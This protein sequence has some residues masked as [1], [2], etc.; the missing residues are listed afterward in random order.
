MA[1]ILLFLLIITY[2]PTA[3]QEVEPCL[4]KIKYRKTPITVD[5]NALFSPI[6]PDER[7]HILASWENFDATSSAITIIKTYNIRPN[8]KAHIISHTAEGKVHY[9]AIIEP[10]Q[11]DDTRQYPLLSFPFGLNQST[12]YVGLDERWLLDELISPLSD[13]WI[14]IPSFRG[15]ALVAG[16]HFYCSDGFFGDAYDGATDDALRLLD[17]ALNQ[18]SNQI[19]HDR[20]SVYGISRGGTVAMLMGIR[21]PLITK[22]IAQSAPNLFHNLDSY[23]RFSWQFQYQ[24]LNEEKP[25]SELRIPMIKSSPYYFLNHYDGQLYILHGQDDPICPIANI[26]RIHSTYPDRS[27][28]SIKVLEGGHMLNGWQQAQIWLQE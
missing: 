18:Y 15:Q 13:Y 25:E 10:T 11:Y 27:N 28:T 24:F 20:I 17:I 1:R 2:I 9:G 16:D 21:E 26:D 23:H 8:R 7:D 14:L 4:S 6:T 19:D 5:I 3:C 22:V 12:P